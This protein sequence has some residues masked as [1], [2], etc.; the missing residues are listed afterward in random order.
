MKNG[1]RAVALACDDNFDRGWQKCILGRRPESPPQFLKLGRCV[2]ACVTGCSTSAVS[3]AERCAELARSCLRYVQMILVSTATPLKTVALAV[4]PVNVVLLVFLYRT[5]DGLLTVGKC[6]LD[7]CLHLEG[8]VDVMG[9][10]GCT[11]MYRGTD[12]V[13]NC[14]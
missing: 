12:L 13:G 1:G 4:Y 14:L 11:D 6:W 5:G 7:L 10:R 9:K 2:C 3:W 8:R